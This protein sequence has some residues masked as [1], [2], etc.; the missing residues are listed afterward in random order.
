MKRHSVVIGIAVAGIVGILSGL[1]IGLKMRRSLLTV[2]SSEYMV[3]SA[4]P[5]PSATPT[6]STDTLY[7]NIPYAFSVRYPASW[8]V[9]ARS[10]RDIG[11]RRAESSGTDAIRIEV[12]PNPA[13]SSLPAF[14]KERGIT[15][16]TVF[17]HH[18]SVRAI[19]LGTV[20]ALRFGAIGNKLGTVYAATGFSVIQITAVCCMEEGYADFDAFV[21]SFRIHQQ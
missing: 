19:M 14:L 8:Y 16:D 3:P 1:L 4:S 21:S 15:L 2:P 12:L 10:D 13:R 6:S 9:S 7:E 20:P 11:F 18:S 17:A 5:A